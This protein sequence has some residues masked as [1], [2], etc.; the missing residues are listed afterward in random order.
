MT[1]SIASILSGAQKYGLG[2]QAPSG[3]KG[4]RQQLFLQSG[5]MYTLGSPA[6]PTTVTFR[7]DSAGVVTGFT[8]RD[9]GV[10]RDLKKVK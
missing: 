1:P 10:D 6:S 8:V 7:M 3:P 2:R 5:T 9:N 4:S